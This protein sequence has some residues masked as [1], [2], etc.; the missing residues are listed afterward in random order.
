MNEDIYDS[1]MIQGSLQDR[2]ASHNMA[3]QSLAMGQQLQQAGAILVQQTNPKKVV[4][5][6]EL[7]LKNQEKTPDGRIL[8]MGKPHLSEL[9]INRIML[10]V[11][12][13][14][15]QGNILSHL[16]EKKINAFMIDL[17]D[18][19]T[20][21]L[22]KNWKKYGIE[23]KTQLDTIHDVVIINIYNTLMRSFGQNEKNWIK[24]ITVETINV[25]N[26]PMPDRRGGFFD[27][28]KL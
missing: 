11:R 3:M 23:D 21:D 10:L 20:D 12:G 17:G 25:G 18:A 27:K 28:F 7:L 16:E 22:S 9:G 1:G 8:Q 19:L 5:D 4:A 2:Q 15:T 14:I 24:G 13:L 26:K 6:I